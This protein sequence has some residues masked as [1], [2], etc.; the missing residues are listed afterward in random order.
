MH[1]L[2]RRAGHRKRHRMLARVARLEVRRVIVGVMMLCWPM[3]VCSQPVV[4]LGMVVIRVG[5]D[6][7]RG[8]LAGRPSPDHCEQHRHHAWHNSECM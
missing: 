4:V 8:D 1:L 3:L 2:Q 6:V 7:Q 5:V